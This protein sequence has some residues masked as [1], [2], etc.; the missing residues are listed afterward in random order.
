M[1][2]FPFLSRL[3]ARKKQSQAQQAFESL[4]ALDLEA[5]AKA[6]LAAS[7]VS[8][9]RI[10]ALYP[11][12]EFAFIAQGLARRIATLPVAQLSSAPGHCQAVLDRWIALPHSAEIYESTYAGLQMG[13]QPDSAARD[14]L[15]NAIVAR[16]SPEKLPPDRTKI[17][18]KV[19]SSARSPMS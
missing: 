8:A 3:A 17:C 2:K 7:G 13:D 9:A 1:P 16:I 11:E 6:E 12:S 4:R 10:A 19:Q 18:C 14:E 5:G 15:I